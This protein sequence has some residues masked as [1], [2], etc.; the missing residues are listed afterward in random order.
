MILV[1]IFK[2]ISLHIEKKGNNLGA[3]CVNLGKFD[4]VILAVTFA[5]FI[6]FAKFW[7]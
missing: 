3:H 2:T 7:F 5:E 4:I 1:N 6:K